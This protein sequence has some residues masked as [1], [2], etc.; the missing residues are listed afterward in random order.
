[1]RELK[2]EI[3]ECPCDNI[4]KI[5]KKCDFSLIKGRKHYKVKNAEGKFITMIPRHTCLAKYT[6]KGIFKKLNEF[7]AKIIIS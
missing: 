2:V 6:A 1:M 7:G 3:A 4:L 5:V